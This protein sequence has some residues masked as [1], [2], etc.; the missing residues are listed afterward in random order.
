MK[1]PLIICIVP[2]FNGERYLKETRDSILA[3]TYRPLEIIV[4]DDGSTDGTPAIVSATSGRR[5]PVRHS[6]G[7]WITAVNDLFQEPRHI[8]GTY[9]PWKKSYWSKASK[10]L[11]TASCVC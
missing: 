7:F 8:P 10:G 2:V 3:Q 5:T 9:E 6:A 1:P 4:A 11:V